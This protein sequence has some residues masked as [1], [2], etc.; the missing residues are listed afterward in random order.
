MEPKVEAVI[1]KIVAGVSVEP[2]RY[3]NSVDVSL[4]VEEALMELEASCS[5]SL[6]DKKHRS[7]AKFRQ[8]SMC[9][10]GM[11][12]LTVPRIS[13]FFGVGRNLVRGEGKEANFRQAWRDILH[14]HVAIEQAHASAD[15]DSSTE[16]NGGTGDGDDVD[17]DANV[18]KTA[19]GVQAEER[20]NAVVALLLFRSTPWDVIPLPMIARV[21][22]RAALVEMSSN[23]LSTS[24][25]CADVE[26]AISTVYSEVCHDLASEAH[27][28]ADLLG[29]IVIRHCGDFFTWLGQNRH[30]LARLCRVAQVLSCIDPKLRAWLRGEEYESPKQLIA[31]YNLKYKTLLQAIALPCQSFDSDDLVQ[32]IKDV[33]REEISVNGTPVMGVNV[34]SELLKAVR[35]ALPDV[36]PALVEMLVEVALLSASRTTA[37][38]D[39]YFI[40]EDLYSSEGMVLVP[41]R[42]R[43]PRSSDTGIAMSVTAKGIHIT[44]RDRHGLYV[45][46][47]LAGSDLAEQAPPMMEFETAMTGFVVF[48]IPGGERERAIHGG[49]LQAFV[50]AAGRE[51]LCRRKFSLRPI[52]P[53]QSGGDVAV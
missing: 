19:V 29:S 35:I 33:Q 46:D 10:F 20:A 51:S 9:R 37:G 15:E 7:K 49:S 24:G 41:M 36:S 5:L 27:M 47:S 6:V 34:Q 8:Q 14:C 4:C 39:G 42:Q 45:Q 52:L 3:L 13:Q 40:V 53:L 43:Q 1:E 26:M 32:A 25:L 18:A 16:K 38:G 44:L 11:L 23:V 31:A 48:D 12:F 30:G 17:A 21:N 2:G 28:N 22:L 50:D